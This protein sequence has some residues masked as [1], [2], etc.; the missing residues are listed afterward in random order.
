MKLLTYDK[1]YTLDLVY[2]I[3]TTI[4]YSKYI[5]VAKK[6]RSTTHTASIRTLYVEYVKRCHKEDILPEFTYNQF[7]KVCECFNLKLSNKII[8]GDRFKLP[9]CRNNLFRIQKY[10]SKNPLLM[11]SFSN[12]LKEKSIN[13]LTNL[14]TAGYSCSFK[15]NDSV[16]NFWGM[17]KCRSIEDMRNRLKHSLFNT[18]NYLKYEEA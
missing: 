2:P 1:V 6:K 18:N 8:E 4:R 7:K 3:P 13:L 11:A 9:Y 5:A 14:H 10:K 12:Y 16:Y 15:V 17:Y